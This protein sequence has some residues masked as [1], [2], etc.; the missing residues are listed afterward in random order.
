MGEINPPNNK[1]LIPMSGI[2]YE[3][4]AGF[5]AS[6]LR[7]TILDD[8]ISRVETGPPQIARK[9]MDKK[10]NTEVIHIA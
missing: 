2:G 3:P 8:L 1:G 6:D 4:L 10:S 5:G 9:R 7:T